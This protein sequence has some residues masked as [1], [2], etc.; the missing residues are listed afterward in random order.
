V[1]EHGLLLAD[2]NENGVDELSHFGE[3]EE[4]YPE[5]SGTA[6]VVGIRR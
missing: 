2:A 4:L 1:K 5:T 3:D 6:A